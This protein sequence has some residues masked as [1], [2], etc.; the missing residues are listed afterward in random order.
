MKS[1]KQWNRIENKKQR[2]NQMKLKTQKR[3]QAEESTIQTA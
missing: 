2:K 1:R 3:I